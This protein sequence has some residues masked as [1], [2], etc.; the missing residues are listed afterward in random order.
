MKTYTIKPLHWFVE[1]DRT[2]T[3]FVK[4]FGTYRIKT[5]SRIPGAR[6]FHTEDYDFGWVAESV[7]EAQRH[8]K[9]HFEKQ[10]SEYLKEQES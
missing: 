9:D 5:S 4:L 3:A 2:L 7:E 10:L 1:K 8:C 6:F